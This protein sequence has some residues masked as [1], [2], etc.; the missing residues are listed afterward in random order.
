MSADRMDRIRRYLNGSVD[1][2]EPRDAAT[3]VLLRD[4]DR[5]L[6]TYLL[7]RRASMAF[8]PGMHVFPG[9]SV[10]VRDRDEQL[11]WAGPPPS[12]WAERF[13]C[14]ITLARALVCAAVRETFEE[15]GIL[16]ASNTDGSLVADTTGEDWE[17]DRLALIDGTLSLS[18]FLGRRALVLRADLLRGWAHWITPEWADRRFDTR[19]FVAA[20]PAGQQTRDV[21]GEADQ[22][23]WLPVA[24]AFAGHRAGTLDM[25]N[26]T[27]STLRELS[28]H[29]AVSSVL[30]AERRIRPRMTR[31]VV[32]NGDVQ[33]VHDA[34]DGPRR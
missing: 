10:D 16:L 1:V 6:E 25:M 19:F 30:A 9:G 2:V 5:G 4:G 11:D 29:R 33:L 3:V 24:E 7:R 26:V 27:A 22:V 20:V 21:G 14:E 12:V 34:E 15:S 17:T 23:T 18:E 31:A 8:G 13:S 32:V 28:E